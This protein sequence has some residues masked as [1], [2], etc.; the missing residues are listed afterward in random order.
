M[1]SS[2]AECSRL[3]TRRGQSST[4]TA[5]KACGGAKNGTGNKPS[6]A[7]SSSQ[8]ANRSGNAINQA[9]AARMRVATCA[10]QRP[11]S[12]SRPIKTAIAIHRFARPWVI[13]QTRVALGQ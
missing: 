11:T 10:D 2:S 12:P 13:G 3:S 5:S 8:T 4:Y 6:L 9:P 1:P 7:V